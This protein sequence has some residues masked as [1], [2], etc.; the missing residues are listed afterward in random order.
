MKTLRFVVAYL[1]LQGS[2]LGRAQ[3]TE[4]LETVA[5]KYHSKAGAE[6]AL[7][8]VLARHWETARRLNLVQPAPHVIVRGAEE[9]DRVY[10][11]EIFTWRDA[12]IPDAAPA[13]IQVL[14]K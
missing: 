6:I 11:L 1:L 13:E 5:V 9:A 2:V 7:A 8:G 4:H 10:L 14:W 3:S 12:G